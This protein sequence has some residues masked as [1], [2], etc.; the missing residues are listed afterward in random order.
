MIIEQLTTLALALALGASIGIERNFAGK[1]AGM[2]TYGLVSMSAALFVL[3]SKF[4]VIDA[5]PLASLDILRVIAG[6]ITGI[7]FL[8]AGLI[9][10]REHTLRG[11]T[12]AAGLWV[13][14]GVGLAVGFGLHVLAIIAA[15]LT[16]I[17]FTILWKIEDVLKQ[18]HEKREK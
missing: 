14:C 10:F 11:L 7:G 13:A 1:T 18:A 15:L 9:I 4:V 17:T 8:G 6:V 12:T 5:G 3:I 2:R 16:I